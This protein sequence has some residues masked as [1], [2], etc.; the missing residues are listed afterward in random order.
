MPPF[1][2]QMESYVRQQL[3]LEKEPWWIAT[4][5]ARMAKVEQS[6]ARGYV[7]GLASKVRPRVAWGYVPRLLAGLVA[8]SAGLVLLYFGVLIIAWLL[9]PIGVGVTTSS[10]YSW[11]RLRRASSK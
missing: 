5:L 2:P 11:R 1:T 4:E 8:L 3:T 7:D 10:W 9:I 6:V